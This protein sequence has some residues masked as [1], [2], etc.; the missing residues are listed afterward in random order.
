MINSYLD[1]VSEVLRRPQARHLI[2]K[3]GL[4]SRIVQE[5]SPMVYLEALR[6][7]SAAAI[8][9]G[10]LDP[11]EDG[12]HFCDLITPGEIKMLLG[13][14]TNQNSLWPYPEQYEQSSKYNGEWTEA[15]EVWFKRQADA[16]YYARKGC[17]RSGKAWQ[18][19][20]QP[21]TTDEYC[22]E[23]TSGTAAH[24][25]ACC[26]HLTRKWPGLWN[27]FSFT[28]FVQSVAIIRTRYLP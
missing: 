25:R 15:N 10:R 13:V 11:D 16:I 6:G 21:Y 2:S 26:T 9:Q 8:D 19:A 27:G 4:L 14:T 3:G 28:S 20:I 7:P 23:T 22:S 12:T 18:N 17:L 5:Y 1:N 24:A